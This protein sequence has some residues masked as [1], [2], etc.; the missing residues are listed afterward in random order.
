MKLF[1]YFL[2]DEE[3]FPV[4]MNGDLLLMDELLTEIGFCGHVVDFMLKFNLIT[5][6]R[7]CNCLTGFVNVYKQFKNLIGSYFAIILQE[8]K[9]D[10]EI[11]TTSFLL[12]ISG[13]NLNNSNLHKHKNVV[14]I[15]QANQFSENKVIKS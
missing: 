2:G 9:F 15:S 11:Y 5:D 4:Q 10:F 6:K 1:Q 7:F 8:G 14:S 3:N 12:Q 13:K